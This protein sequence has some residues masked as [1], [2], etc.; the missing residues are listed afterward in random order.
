MSAA[1]TGDTELDLRRAGEWKGLT[2]ARGAL[3]VL[4]VTMFLLDTVSFSLNVYLFFQ[5]TRDRLLRGIFE[6]DVLV[7]VTVQKFV[8]T[9]DAVNNTFFLLMV[10]LTISL[11]VSH[12][13]NF[14]AHLIPGD[15]IVI[16]RAYAVWTRSKLITL[17]PVLFLLGCIVN[18]P[19]FVACSIQHK[20]DP[21]HVP[22]PL[23]PACFVTNTF[24]WI[25]SFC[26]NIFATVIIFYTAWSYY[27][28]QRALQD[29]W[30]FRPRVSRVAWILL[31]LVDSDFAYF[32]VLVIW[33]LLAL[34]SEIPS[35]G[36]APVTVHTFGTILTQCI[37]IVPTITVLLVNLYGSFRDQSTVD[38][39]QPIRFATPGR[40]TELTHGSALSHPTMRR[41]YNTEITEFESHNL[42]ILALRITAL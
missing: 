36:P 31:L 33:I 24:A 17:I 41:E 42:R 29:I 4:I 10:S 34:V 25:L 15:C 13:P 27:L 40:L 8:A 39:S 11:S 30:A 12:I 6:E 20:Y 3:L 16:W 28:S 7:P 18:L 14:P 1:G 37:G 23:G 35:Y 22:G 32:L 19:S 5:Q 38:I 2:K 26:A 9:V 21:I